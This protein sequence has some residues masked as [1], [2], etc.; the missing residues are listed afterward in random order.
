MN[1]VLGEVRVVGVPHQADGDDLRTVEEDAGHPE[2]LAALTLR[3][4]RRSV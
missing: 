1:D 3:R 4:R 2:L